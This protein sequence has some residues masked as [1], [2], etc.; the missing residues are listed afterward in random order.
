MELDFKLGYQRKGHVLGTQERTHMDKA[1]SAFGTV[2][3]N[4]SRPG[5]YPTG[6]LVSSRKQWTE[7]T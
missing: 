4:I 7:Y 1:S 3:R 2:G 5:Y 6:T